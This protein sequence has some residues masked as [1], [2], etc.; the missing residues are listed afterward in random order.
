[1]PYTC[2][3]CKKIFARHRQL[4]AHLAEHDGEKPFECQFC[5]RE[6]SKVDTF[7]AHLKSHADY[8]PLECHVCRETF[9]NEGSRGAH[10]KKCADKKTSTCYLCKKTFMY[11][12]HLQE[13]LRTHKG[14]TPFKCQ[15]CQLTFT[16]ND[17]LR[18]HRRIKH[19]PFLCELC[20]NT[21]IDETSLNFHMESHSRYN[22]QLLT[23]RFETHLQSSTEDKRL[24]SFGSHLNNQDFVSKKQTNRGMLECH[25]CDLVFQ[26]EHKLRLHV[27]LKHN[28]YC[29]CCRKTFAVE[30]LWSKHLDTCKG[31]NEG[32]SLD[33]QSYKITA[34][35]IGDITKHIVTRCEQE[36]EVVPDVFHHNLAKGD[37]EDIKS[38]NTL[39]IPYGENTN[40]G[41][42]HMKKDILTYRDQAEK[43]VG[44][45]FDDVI[46]ISDSEDVRSLP[47][48]TM[49]FTCQLCGT[50]FPDNES[51]KN[52]LPIHCSDGPFECSL[53]G[54]SFPSDDELKVH[55]RIHATKELLK[56]ELCDETFYRS[57]CLAY[58]LETHMVS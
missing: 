32:N 39:D 22:L 21:F 58:H 48:E 11:D 42:D 50:S 49:P 35:D 10:M 54:L 51:L 28:V 44:N 37:S 30:D 8:R 41:V 23:N 20:G 19:R 46:M 31:Y 14:E 25:L 55:L 47:I 9:I 3:V 57:D 15:V 4:C 56:C 52:H 17:L 29:E 2:Y 16:H 18:E 5:T 7:K 36:R 13:H 6:F 38:N 40:V 26:E 27:K 43:R 53:C 1:M 45:S 24:E 12:F 33:D 34:A